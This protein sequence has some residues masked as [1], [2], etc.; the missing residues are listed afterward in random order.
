ML[1]VLDQLT[2]LSPLTW[3]RIRLVASVAAAVGLLVAFWHLLLILL[4]L[5][6]S[7]LTAYSL[8]PLVRA[9]HRT[10]LARRWPGPSRFI[11][12]SAAAALA[13]AIV[14]GLIALIVWALVDGVNT[15]T[16]TVPVLLAGA[17]GDWMALEAFYRERV[18]ATVQAA[19]D[20]QL[21]KLYDSV[22]DAATQAIGRVASA[23]QSNLAQLITLVAAPATI[24]QMLYSPSALSTSGRRLVPGPLQQDLSE[25]VRL[26]GGV[27]VSYFRIQLLLGAMVGVVIFLTYR[28]LGIPLALALGLLGVLSELVP[29]IGAPIFVILTSALL[30]LTDVSKL[31]WALGIFV[32]VQVVQIAVV[33]PRLQARALG[34]HPMAVVVAMAVFTVFFGLLG[35]LVAAPLAAAAYQVLRYVGREWGRGGHPAGDAV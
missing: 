31:P 10:R 5:V 30:V 32:I 19:V 34:L 29:V 22:L 20:P 16:E 28:A 12:A 14:L 4:P 13:V 33:Q 25:M 15:L 18:P 21:A 3:R 2:N 6:I 7:G 17:S 8:M 9:G 27:I 24:F 11:I 23:A 1:P 35:A 26:A